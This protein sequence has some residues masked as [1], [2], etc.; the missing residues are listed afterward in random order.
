MTKLLIV[1]DHPLFRRGICAYVELLD[2]Y[3]ITAEAS[4]GEQA[5]EYLRSLDVDTVLLDIDIP[6]ID[7]FELLSII[8][9]QYSKT[10]VIMLTMHDEVAYAIKAFALG[11][12]AFLVKDDAEELLVKCLD[13]VSSGERFNSLGNLTTRGGELERLSESE[14]HIFNLVS[15]GKSSFIIAQLLMLSV[16][17]VDNHRGNI[18]KKLGLRG[19][20]A[21]LKYAISKHILD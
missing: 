13:A 14:R 4:N 10:K 5:L 12:D 16:R 15:S 1:D 9:R 20:N 3:T 21:L 8:R 18:S 11:A 2:G 17:T 6:M 19:P 7:G